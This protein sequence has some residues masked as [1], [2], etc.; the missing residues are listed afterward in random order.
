MFEEL[1]YL[2]DKKEGFIEYLKVT[3]ILDR[4]NTKKIK[5]KK[6]TFEIMSDDIAIQKY[7]MNPLCTEYLQ[8]DNGIGDIVFLEYKELKAIN[9]QIE[10][11]GWNNE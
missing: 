9:K 1:G 8:I 10:E 7:E 4:I 6:I 2:Y 5:F 11:L 3:P